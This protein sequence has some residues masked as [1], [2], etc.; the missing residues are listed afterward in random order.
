MTS[1]LTELISSEL[2]IVSTDSISFAFIV[3]GLW[4]GNQSRIRMVP[5]SNSICQSLNGVQ[6]AEETSNMTRSNTFRS[7]LVCIRRL[8][9]MA[10]LIDPVFKLPRFY[11]YNLYVFFKKWRYASKVNFAVSIT[12]YASVSP[13]YL[14]KV[15]Y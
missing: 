9:I 14:E 12:N 13:V 4:K 5:Q 3:I 8:T 15:N 6:F 7:N 2:K 11:L 1:S 10:T